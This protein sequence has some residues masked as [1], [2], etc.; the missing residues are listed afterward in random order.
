M[1]LYPSPAWRRVALEREG[2]AA[3]FRAHVLPLS[4]LAPLA[5]MFGMALIARQEMTGVPLLS[6]SEVLRAGM[7]T[8]LFS[9]LMPFPLALIIRLL[10]PLFSLRGDFAAAFRVA[11]YS[12]TPLWLAG[13]LLLAPSLVTAAAAALLHFLYLM[14]RGLEIV[15]GAET[16]TSA[17]YTALV[18]MGISV[19][20]MPVGWL[21]AY[22]GLM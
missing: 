4:L 11:A 13:V 22:V 3:L 2:V 1:V 10:A 6:G 17:E 9:A 20:L 14:T 12:L 19:F 8:A 15:L 21:A 16:E 5:S 7:T 18:S